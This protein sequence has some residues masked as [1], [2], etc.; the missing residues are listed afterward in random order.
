M[1]HHHSKHVPNV[2]VWA[3]TVIA[4]RVADDVQHLK[5]VDDFPEHGV[6]AIQ[7]VLQ[8]VPQRDIELGA[9]CVCRSGVCHGHCAGLGV[10]K[11]PADLVLEEAV[12][13]ADPGSDATRGAGGAHRR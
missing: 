8:P 7:L 11:L 10:G 9:V 3:P 4:V 5:P 12:L 13:F 1:V 6:F 2:N